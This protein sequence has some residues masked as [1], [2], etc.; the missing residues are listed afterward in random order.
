MKEKEIGGR[1]DIF[2]SYYIKIVSMKNIF[3]LIIGKIKK[4]TET[5][6][7]SDNEY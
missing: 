3:S 5:F 2:E 7:E 4:K 1:L 6:L